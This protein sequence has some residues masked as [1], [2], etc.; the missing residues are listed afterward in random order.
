VFSFRLLITDQQAASGA[1]VR[2]MLDFSVDTEI[3]ITTL[4]PTR[5]P[6]PLRPSAG[7]WPAQRVARQAW[8]SRAGRRAT[9]RLPGLAEAG[10]CASRFSRVTGGDERVRYKEL[11]GE[12]SLHCLQR[13]RY[14]FTGL[15]CGTPNYVSCASA[16]SSVC[17]RRCRKAAMLDAIKTLLL[18]E[19][20][21]LDT[22]SA[23][24]ACFAVLV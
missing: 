2:G 13:H 8:Q 17:M 18:E 12:L 6:C 11:R 20:A 23:L 7:V 19:C 21:G 4:A 1:R 24:H 16:C 3:L 10:G 22:L 15:A 14:V 9:S 5:D